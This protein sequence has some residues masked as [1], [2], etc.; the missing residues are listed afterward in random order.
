[1]ATMQ[2]DLFQADATLDDS[3]AGY[4]GTCKACKRTSRA[5]AA[6]L[7]AYGKQH[8]AHCPHGCTYKGPCTTT[9]FGKRVSIEYHQIQ[10]THNPRIRCGFK[11]QTAT[12]PACHCS[13][14]GR[15]HGGR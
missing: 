15:N 8:F 14:N 7:T 6:Q 4:I 12:G 1:M 13:C 9:L 3:P 10:A 2:F 5:T 11:C